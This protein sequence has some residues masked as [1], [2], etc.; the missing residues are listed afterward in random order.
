MITYWHIIR[1]NRLWRHNRNTNR[2]PWRCNNTHFKP[3]SVAT[4]TACNICGKILQ[5]RSRLSWHKR[6][7]HTARRYS[8]GNCTKQYRRKEDLA[9][10]AK[11]YDRIPPATDDALSVTPPAVNTPKASPTSYTIVSLYDTWFE[12]MGEQDQLEQLE[13]LRSEDTPRRLMITHTIGSYWIPSQQNNRS[14]T[15]NITERTRFSKSRSNDLE[16][17]GQ[18]QRSSHATHLLMLVIICTKYGKNPSRTVDA[19]ERTRFSR[20]RPND[21]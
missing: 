3:T 1:Q 5:H 11:K 2:S 19:T 6:T 20:S 9:K 12:N 8:C 16:D 13:R 21:L 7:Q 15:E 17:I 14:R 4:M 18:G 10:H